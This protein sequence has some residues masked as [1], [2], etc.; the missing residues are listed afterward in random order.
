[1]NSGNVTNIQRAVLSSYLEADN[2]L[3][4]SLRIKNS[5]FTIPLHT[6]IVKCVLWLLEENRESNDEIVLYYIS[7]KYQVDF[8]EWLEILAQNPLATKGTIESYHEV[9]E[10]NSKRVAYDI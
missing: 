8:N 7:K 1:M 6:F 9:L 2:E 10:D 4:S 3:L 5:W